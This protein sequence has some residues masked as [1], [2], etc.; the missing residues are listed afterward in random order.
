MPYMIKG[1]SKGITTL[2]KH[3]DIQH[4]GLIC[5]TQHENILNVNIPKVVLV[6]LG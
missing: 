5:S 6:R 1:H 4:K 3:N 2:R